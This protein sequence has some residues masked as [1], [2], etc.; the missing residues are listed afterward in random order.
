MNRL[1]LLATGL[2]LTTAATF[3]QSPPKSAITQ[4]GAP[5]P[6]AAPPRQLVPLDAR[7]VRLEDFLWKARPLVVFADT[8]ADPR[9]LLQME[10][11]DARPADLIER[12]VV[13]ITD[14]DP[15][16]NS[17]ARRKLRPRGFTFVMLDKDGNV[18]LRKPQPWST[19]ELSRAIDKTPL[20]QEELRALRDALPGALN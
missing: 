4:P 12:D 5:G 8:P 3:A 6:D 11:L 14:T 20:R 19:R 18:I 9:F 10:R 7:D 17:E 15:A 16:A 13:V 2:L 1:V